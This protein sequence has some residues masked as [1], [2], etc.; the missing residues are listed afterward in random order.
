MFPGVV[1]GETEVKRFTGAQIVSAEQAAR[2]LADDALSNAISVVSQAISVADAALSVRIDTQSQAISVLSQAVS[3]L[4]Q[5]VSVLSLLGG[6][7]GSVTST[8]LSAVSAQAAS[9]INV[10]SGQVIYRGGTSVISGT[11]LAD[12]ASM[13]ISCA[14]GGVYQIEGM[15]CFEKATSGG[16][17]FGCSVPALA[18]AGSYIQ[19]QAA[20]S[21]AQAGVAGASAMALGRVA[22]SAVAASNT[23][24]VSVSVATI[25]AIRGVNIEGMLAVS[26]A[27]TFRM[28]ARGSVAGDSL[29]VRGGFLRAYRV[30]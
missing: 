23:A 28:M 18:A 13:V 8:E 15:L 16:A 24:V 30:A 26:A 12:I 29:S 11:A 3:V 5:Q 21:I 17:A 20:A 9:A 4:S 19:M 22:L 6:G 14:A 10:L 2:I 27:G 1:A 7:G 25:N